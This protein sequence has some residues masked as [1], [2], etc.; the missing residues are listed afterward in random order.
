MSTRLHRST[1]FFCSSRSAD[2]TSSCPLV[3]SHSE[4]MI[5]SRSVHLSQAEKSGES[6]EEDGRGEGAEVASTRWREGEGGGGGRRGGEGGG[7]T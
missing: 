5:A 6:E 4:A 1:S 3:R 7:G 2:L